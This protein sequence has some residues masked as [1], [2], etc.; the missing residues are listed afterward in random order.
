VLWFKTD[1][2]VPAVAVEA[3]DDRSAERAWPVG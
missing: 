3:E 1:G 2:V